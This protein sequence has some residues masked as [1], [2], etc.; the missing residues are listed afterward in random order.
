MS[1]ETAA[2]HR[3]T[4]FACRFII[5]G[6]GGFTAVHGKRIRMNRGDVILTPTWNWHDHGKDG[7]GPMIW[8]DGLDL[9]NFMHFPVHFVEHYQ[10]PRCPAEDADSLASPLVFPWTMMKERLDK[11]EGP[12]ATLSYVKKDGS[13]SKF[14]MTFEINDLI[15]AQSV[16]P[17]VLPHLGLMLV[18][19]VPRYRTHLRPCSMLLKDQAIQSSKARSIGGLRAILSASPHGT[20]TS[21]TPTMVSRCTCI[22]AMMSP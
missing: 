1:N 5:E 16:R 7:S 9:P 10:D 19:R 13:E 12:N 18:L 20:G 4:A 2:A 15:H 11:V 3:H 21:I 22:D 17:L 14:R 6:N 8:L